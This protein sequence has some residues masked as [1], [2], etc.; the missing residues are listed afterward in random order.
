MR[1]YS[2]NYIFPVGNPPI[3]NGIIEVDDEGK[4]VSIINPGSSF[5]EI[6]STEFHNG[7]IIPGFV[8]AHCHLE[9][10]HLLGKIPKKQG[11]ASFIKAVTEERLKFQDSTQ[12]SIANAI[13]ELELTGTVA[14]GDICN[15]TDTLDLKVKSELHFHNFIEVF[16]INQN[17][18]DKVFELANT[19]KT[20]FLENY[21]GST[22]ITPHSTYSLSK[23]LW[24]RVSTEINN[25]KMPVSIHFAES[26][27]EYEFLKTGSGPI[28]DRYKFLS[29]PFE[30]P[31]GLSP[32][33]VVFNN[34]DPNNDVLLIH[35][36][37]ASIDELLQING[38]YRKV[39]FVTCPESNIYIE[40]SMPALAEMHKAGLRIAI[41]T[42]SL[43]S[44]STLSMLYHIN[45]LLDNF[46]EISFADILKWATLNGAEAL[47]IES[48]FGTLEVGKNPGLNLI[49]D[50]DFNSM[51]PTLKS[52][53]KRLV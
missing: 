4:I 20:R 9:L 46:K 48:R 39:T 10:S 49:T 7:I 53:V 45:L 1:R 28:F 22:S 51:K 12:K 37:F 25:S 6:H 44:A 14:V 24:N 35:N 19:I 32:L 50:F 34:V 36:T 43:A 11:I 27:P 41:G 18:S 5:K 15:T 31:F 29:I 3:K 13:K 30:T 21:P 33:D 16:G 17:N 52:R 26:L 40:N 38:H 42:D 2:A 47:N 23:N 8:N